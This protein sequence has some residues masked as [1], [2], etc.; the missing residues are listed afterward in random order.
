MADDMNP[1][2]SEDDDDDELASDDDGELPAPLPL[3]MLG[4]ASSGGK[5][6]QKPKP[7]PK[8]PT[9][10]KLAKKPASPAP[11]PPSSKPVSR[12]AVSNPPSPPVAA[13]PNSQLPEATTGT[14]GGDNRASEEAPAPTDPSAAVASATTATITTTTTASPTNEASD[15]DDDSDDDGKITTPASMPP[16]LPIAEPMSE[17]EGASEPFDAAKAAEQ[18]RKAGMGGTAGTSA[19]N[20]TGS[21]GG[22]GASAAK[23]S[24][25]IERSPGVVD[26]A[27]LSLLLM[28]KGEKND[29]LAQ[30]PM[31]L[32]VHGLVKDDEDHTWPPY[33]I[34]LPESRK[35]QASRQAWL[36]QK[37]QEDPNRLLNTILFFNIDPD[38]VLNS[39]SAMSASEHKLQAILPGVLV[40]PDGNADVAKRIAEYNESIGS[41]EWTFA[42]PVPAQFVKVLYKQ[43]KHGLPTLYNPVSNDKVRFSLFSKIEE[44]CSK[45]ARWRLVVDKSREGQQAT[46]AASGGGAAGG[47][48]GRGKRAAAAAGGEEGTVSKKRAKPSAAAAT[49]D[50]AIT[51]TEPSRGEEPG[52]EPLE[53]P[54]P[55][56][57]SMPIAPPP[58]PIP[59]NA[60]PTP[61]VQQTVL[62][63]LPAPVVANGSPPP[64][65]LLQNLSSSP[66]RLQNEPPLEDPPPHFSKSPMPL[67]LRPP[68][69]NASTPTFA[70]TPPNWT[71]ITPE[72]FSI[73]VPKIPEGFV[74]EMIAPT[75]HCSGMLSFKR[76]SKPVANPLDM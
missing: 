28:V 40:N 44:Q 6:S 15:Q 56:A 45:D 31:E 65:Q 57:A 54:P 62:N 75:V 61:A 53:D 10:L 8:L 66:P 34:S 7:A 14:G 52:E 11:D 37:M 17:D 32:C 50:S 58:A 22:G 18:A 73:I 76:S 59:Q 36:N 26:E 67:A 41:T 21:G 9:S 55:P 30:V 38:A 20:G 1:S 42:I 51:N 49:A 29:S 33:E 16:H 24:P 43:H 71:S 35:S 39:K 72:W 27:L 5:K 68:L 19:A 70:H 46:A 12:V 2:G 23:A 48:G 69:A 60:A 63:F 25:L 3:A 47:G 64:Q 4:V 74:V 13:T